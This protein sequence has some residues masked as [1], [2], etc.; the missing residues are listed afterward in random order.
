[1][2]NIKF[3][4]FLIYLIIVSLS[5]SPSFALGDGNRNLFLISVMGLSPIIIISSKKF[6]TL[7]FWIIITSIS[8]LVGSLFIFDKS[9]R[10]STVFYSWM[11][12]LTFGAYFRLLNLNFFTVFQFYR[13][14][15]SLIM[16][17]FLTLIIQQFCVLLETPIFNISNYN[18]SEPWKL[19]S[20]SAE[21]SH[22]GRIVGL[23]FYCLL[24]VKEIFHRRKYDFK[25]DFKNDWPLWLAFLW[26]MLTMGSS[27]AYIFVTIIYFKLV[28]FRKIVITFLISMVIIFFISDL[29][30]KSIDRLFLTIKAVL[31]L[32]IRNIISADHS[33]SFRIVPLFV[34]IS[35]LEMFSLIGMFGHG[36]DSVNSFLYR[37]IPGGGF[38]VIGGGFLLVWYEYGFLS[39]ILI[40]I[41]NL[42]LVQFNMS[43][44]DLLF[45]ILLVFLNGINSQISW[46]CV[47]LLF[48]V[49][50]FKFS[51]KIV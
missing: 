7:D 38:N 32:D 10:W 3:K 47:T 17:Y 11:F 15:R 51:N 5:T 28:G 33:A 43:I 48:T 4:R 8:L 29:G 21:P 16:A 34:I 24:C 12:F 19:N 23:L 22:S 6:Y 46:L 45:W 2:N 26:P 25:L 44:F 20:L 50:F 41:F 37:Y 30:I 14:L 36:I 40:L 13:L 18:Y 42:K 39:F 1:M 31:S 49:S 9:I 27:T 35:K